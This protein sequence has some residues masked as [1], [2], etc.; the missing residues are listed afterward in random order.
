[1]SPSY[2]GFSSARASNPRI[3]SWSCGSERSAG[4]FSESGALESASSHKP[5]YL[6]DVRDTVLCVANALLKNL[7]SSRDHVQLFYGRA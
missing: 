2:I 1:M 3:S 6:H 5:S 7:D 4:R